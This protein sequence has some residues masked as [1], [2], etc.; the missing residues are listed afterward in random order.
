MAKKKTAAAA[1]PE[2][3]VYCGLLIVSWLALA[4]ACGLLAWEISK[5]YGW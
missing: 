1:A 2:M 5:T 4:T 3:D